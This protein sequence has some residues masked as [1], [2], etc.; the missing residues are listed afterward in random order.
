M[1]IAHGL[2]AAHARGIVHRDLKPEN[3][4]IG[5]DSVVKLLDFGLARITL[6][7][8]SAEEASTLATTGAGMVLGTA[9]YMA[10]EQVHGLPADHRADIFACGAILLE[11]LSGRRAFDAGSTAEIMTAI[12]TKDPLAGRDAEPSLLDTRTAA[13]P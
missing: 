10:P 11:M 3:V 13:Q 6:T 5:R 2:V 4:F 1:G 12:L 7:P 8:P 9:G